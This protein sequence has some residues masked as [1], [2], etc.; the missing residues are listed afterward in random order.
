MSSQ[1][2]R[3]DAYIAKAAPFA[4]PILE[5][6]RAVVHDA[7]P[8]VE[9]TMKWGMPHFDYKGMMCSMA[10]FKAHCAMNFW[11]GRQVLG[12]NIT[13]EAM[14]QFGRITSVKDLPS[15]TQLKRYIKTAM[16]LNDAG[17]KLSRP[18]AKKGAAAKPVAVPPELAVALARH[19]AAQATFDAF[20]PS[21]RRE[22]CEWI[23]E[24][25]RPE[26]KAKRVEQAIE[27]LAE[28]KARNWKYGA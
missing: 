16:A 24:A 26:T 22:Y 12:E 19:E 27:L 20:S 18:A 7:C 8:D 23:A 21:H 14:G 4:Q 28:G 5:H 13:D 15:K 10:S 1:D 17:V 9:E 11:L 6:I 25:K 2:A 3:I